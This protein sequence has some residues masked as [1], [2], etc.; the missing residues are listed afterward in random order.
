MSDGAPRSAIERV[1]ERFV[2]SRRSRVLSTHAA[3][4]LPLE[5][6]VLDV[7]C[8]DGRLAALIKQQRPDLTM[9]GIDV[10]ARPTPFIPVELFDGTTIPYEA[11][12]FDAVMFVDTLHHTADPNVLLREGAR[13]AKRGVLIKDHTRDGWLAGPTL[14]F[15]DRVG[16]ARHGVALPHVYWPKAEWMRAF[17]SLGLKLEDWRPRLGLYPWP[18][19]AVFERTLHFMAWLEK[20]A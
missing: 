4:M 2:V 18:A 7:G 13:V 20:R 10:L 6:R 3:D 1:H 19:S 14:R 8:G 5:A 12:S 9:V 17:G 16:N 15:M 11:G